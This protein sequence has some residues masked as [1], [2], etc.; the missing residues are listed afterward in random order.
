MKTARVEECCFSAIV[1]FGL[2]ATLWSRWEGL[3]EAGERS[4]FLCL[5]LKG[6]FLELI[7]LTKYTTFKSI[8]V[9]RFWKSRDKY[10]AKVYGVPLYLFRMWENAKPQQRPPFFC[11]FII[12]EGRAL[13]SHETIKKTSNLLFLFDTVGCHDPST[14]LVRNLRS[15][16]VSWRFSQGDSRNVNGEWACW[17]IL[18]LN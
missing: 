4:W 9:G 6:A 10:C 12:V 7:E 2:F 15:Y 18:G 11:L 14:S 1:S 3:L 8:I 16:A 17:G 5:L 13:D